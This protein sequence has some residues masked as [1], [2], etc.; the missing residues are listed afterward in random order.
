MKLITGVMGHRCESV[1]PI[2]REMPSLNGSVL[3]ESDSRCICHQSIGLPVD[4]NGTL[5]ELQHPRISKIQ[6]AEA[7]GRP[8][9]L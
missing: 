8:Q 5:E 7:C 1:A 4:Q 3:D 2:N 9:H 6:K